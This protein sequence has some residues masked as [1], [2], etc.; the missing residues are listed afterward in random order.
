MFKFF[1][2][3]LFLFTITYFLKNKFIIAD[4]GYSFAKDYLFNKLEINKTKNKIS[5]KKKS[6]D[7]KK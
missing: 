1:L 2:I 7:F 3:P 5:I 4:T 6:T